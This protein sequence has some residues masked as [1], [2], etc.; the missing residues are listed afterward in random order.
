MDAAP[1][2]AEKE[3]AGTAGWPEAHHRSFLASKAVARELART[4][5][6]DKSVSVLASAEAFAPGGL[7]AREYKEDPQDRLSLGAL[8][9]D[10]SLGAL[11]YDA[12]MEDRRLDLGDGGDGPFRSLVEA[13]VAQDPG[14]EGEHALR[15]M[16]AAAADQGD[17][18]KVT[19]LEPE[20]NPS[21]WPEVKRPI[22]Y[23]TY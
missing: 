5:K 7:V 16:Q 2:F 13:I 15:K 3:D 6:L 9:Y 14:V 22:V 12:V 18:P 17:A 21:P 23:G 1:T 8:A 20:A 11:A 4:G 10:A 19:A